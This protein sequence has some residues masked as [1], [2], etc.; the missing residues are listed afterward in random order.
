MTT[1]LMVRTGGGIRKCGG[2]SNYYIILYLTI[3]LILSSFPN[4]S[5]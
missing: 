4:K 3:I 1:E 2:K 5:E